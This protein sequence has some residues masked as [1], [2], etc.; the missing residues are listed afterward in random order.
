MLFRSKFSTCNVARDTVTFPSS[1]PSLQFKHLRVGVLIKMRDAGV[2]SIRRAL[3]RMVRTPLLLLLHPAHL[4]PYRAGPPK[5]YTTS[6]PAPLDPNPRKS[7]SSSQ[8]AT[9]SSNSGG[10]PKR[11][12]AR[13]TGTT[14]LKRCSSVGTSPKLSQTCGRAE[15]FWRVMIRLLWKSLRDG[16]RRRRIWRRRWRRRE[17]RLWGV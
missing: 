14:S 10:S 11:P 16:G 1:C 12:Y 17:W 15:R 3:P 9:P 13:I 8:Q 7:H 6:G 5:T 4:F 2:F